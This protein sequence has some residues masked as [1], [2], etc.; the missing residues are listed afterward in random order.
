MVKANKVAQ[1]VQRKTHLYRDTIMD[2]DVKQGEQDTLFLS[3]YK[4]IPDRLIY[5]T[6]QDTNARDRVDPGNF[7]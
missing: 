5:F 7:A 6:G 4:F 3:T 2:C 1:N